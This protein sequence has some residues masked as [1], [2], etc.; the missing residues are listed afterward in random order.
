MDAFPDASAP[1][2]LCRDRDSI[3][4]QR[5]KGMGISEVLTAPLSPWQNQFAERL[6]GSRSGAP[7]ASHGTWKAALRARAIRCG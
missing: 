1:S 5:V 6:I 2:Y 3:Y 4:G 7:T